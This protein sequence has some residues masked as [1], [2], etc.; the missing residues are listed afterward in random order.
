MLKKVWLKQFMLIFY[1]ICCVRKFGFCDINIQT[2][3]HKV[4]KHISRYPVLIASFG[5][6]MAMH[7][8]LK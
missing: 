1:F 5:F 4:P 6:I 2:V 3:T 8:F 7:D